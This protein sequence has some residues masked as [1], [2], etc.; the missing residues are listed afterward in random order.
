MEGWGRTET[1]VVGIDGSPGG[2]RALQWAIAEAKRTGRALRVIRAFSDT[3]QTEVVVSDVETAVNRARGQGVAACGQ[4]VKAQPVSGL[5]DHS[6]DA[7][8]L[9]VGS[10]GLSPL[11]MEMLG[12]VSEAC[13]REAHVPVVV[14]PKPDPE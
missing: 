11:A 10:R 5:L 13:V 4:P 1:I 2:Q 6:K 9:V 14:I 12:S 8:M 7:A 3:E